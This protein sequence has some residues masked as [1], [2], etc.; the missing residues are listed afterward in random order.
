[1]FFIHDIYAKSEQVAKCIV[2]IHDI[3]TWSCDSHVI[4]SGT[5]SSTVLPMTRTYRSPLCL[6]PE[7]SALMRA[8]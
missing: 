3:V 8:E 2:V 7:L 5:G 6:F 1:M 4:T